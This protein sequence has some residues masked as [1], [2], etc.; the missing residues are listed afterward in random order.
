MK[1]LVAFSVCSAFG[2]TT[3]SN[4][5]DGALI[6]GTPFTAIGAASMVRTERGLTNIV[7]GNFADVCSIADE[8]DQGSSA[9]L[10]LLLSDFTDANDSTPP[11]QPG[12]YPVSSPGDPLPTSGPYA[13]CGFHVTDA[14][15]EGTCDFTQTPCTSGQITLTRADATGYAGMLD[16]MIDGDHVTGTFDTTNCDNVSED[17]LGT[18][19]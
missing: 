7:L 1:A 2:C 16:V 4:V 19:H 12:T 10:T 6:A 18:C 9:T 3:T 5:N 8:S 13:A 15:T 14:A 17:G 11:M